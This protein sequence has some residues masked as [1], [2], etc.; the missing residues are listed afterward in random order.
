MFPG[1]EDGEWEPHKIHTKST[2]VT[3]GVNGTQPISQDIEMHDTGAIDQQSTAT[4]PGEGG[5]TVE[6]YEEDF[7]SSEG[8]VYPMQEGHIVNHACF[9]AL[10]SH[11]YNTLSP[12]FH[13]PVLVIAQPAWSA[14]DKEL[15]TRFFFE[16]FNI[17]AL[18]FMDS[19]VAACFAYGVQSGIVVDIGQGKCD[20][21]AVSDFVV[22]NRG[23]G[24]AIAAGGSEALT[25]R[26]LESLEPQGFDRS[27]CE[28]LKKTQ[29]CEVLA[30]STDLPKP[31]PAN[32][33]PAAAAS[34]GAASSGPDAK[35]ADG[36][37]PGQA[38]PRGP[39]EGTEV[40]EEGN[41][42]EEDNEGVLDVASIVAKG[43][44][45]EYL[46]KREKEKR[47]RLAA[48]KGGPVDATHSARLKNSEKE[49]AVFEVEEY[50]T[51]EE[52]SDN[53]AG[54]RKRKRDMEVGPERF[55][56]AEPPRDSMY[57]V[58]DTIAA[59]I[60]KVVV[61]VLEVP[62]RAELWEA[63]IILGNGSKLRG[64]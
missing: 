22:Q 60:H 63:M 61:S 49:R 5:Q 36:I 57:G 10:L 53:V 23:R 13:T 6:S 30:S 11:I 32:S 16:V 40:G 15:I 14:R 55:E 2:S 24:A 38:L 43:N 18:A 64:T 20:V 28:Q 3:N 51:S 1:Q 27:M 12:P 59:A 45:S 54:T 29:I 58:V 8:A 46:A 25:R 42:A 17:P 4:Q 62:K 34:T 39:G 33:N 50:L 56:A 21:T 52:S 7:E 44:A 47:E 19:A 26:L 48:R 9:F 41:G 31:G 37:A 35:E